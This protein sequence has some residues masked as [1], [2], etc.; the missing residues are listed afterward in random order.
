MSEHMCI[1]FSK[2]CRTFNI[3]AATGCGKTVFMF[4]VIREHER[5]FETKI[6]SILYSY[7]V[8]QHAFFELEKEMGDKIQFIQGLASKEQLLS[9]KRPMI[10]IID[11]LCEEAYNSQLVEQIFC[12]LAH[13]EYIF[14]FLLSQNIFYHGTKARTIQ[15]NS[16]CTI[17]LRNTRDKYQISRI[18]RSM[19]S[20]NYYVVLDAYKD[21]EENSPNGYF[22][23]I[24]DTSSSCP[25]QLRVRS[26]IFKHDSPVK[27]Y[28]PKNGTAL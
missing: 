22:Y 3:C 14:C 27:V 4:N 17:L 23:I 8:Y 26:G 7:N 15:L 16:C 28:L 25:S 12:V 13:H 11:D 21:S 18:A 19:F 9:C 6:E 10:Y 1:P 5:L 2:N 24:L 20:E